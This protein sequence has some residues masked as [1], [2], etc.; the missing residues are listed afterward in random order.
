MRTCIILH[1]M[2]VE[3]ERSSET[4]D[5]VHEFEE[6]EEVATFSVNMPSPIVSTIDRRTSVQNTQAHHNL[7]NDLI[8][9]I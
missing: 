7:K 3:D 8:D 5:N 1:N 6:G 2:I 4:E 9:N